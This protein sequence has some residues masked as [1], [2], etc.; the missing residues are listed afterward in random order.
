MH[1][2]GFIGLLIALYVSFVS[3]LC[4]YMYLYVFCIGKGG[5]FVSV[6]MYFWSFI[7]VYFVGVECGFFPLCVANFLFCDCPFADATFCTLCSA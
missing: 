6:Y 5:L 2:S 4:V 3:H 7:H 1:L